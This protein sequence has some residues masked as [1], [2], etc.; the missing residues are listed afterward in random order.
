MR[1]IEAGEV[2]KPLIREL[3]YSTECSACAGQYSDKKY[4]DFDAAHDSGFYGGDAHIV[5]DDLA[6]CA[7]CVVAAASLLGMT[8]DEDLK[9]EVA[10]LQEQLQQTERQLRK[11]EEYADRIEEAFE[12]RPKGPVHVDHR[13][14]PRKREIVDGE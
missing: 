12:H 5:K 6:L 14:K 2:I 1:V 10:H 13:K 8:D 9:Q 3:G 7:D 11:V 4:I